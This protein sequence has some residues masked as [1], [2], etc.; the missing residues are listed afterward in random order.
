MAVDIIQTGSRKIYVNGKLV[1]LDMNNKW[2]STN[3]LTTNEK[4]A[5]GQVLTNNNLL[6]E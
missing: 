3:E 6:N 4:E 1:A 5:L 2:V